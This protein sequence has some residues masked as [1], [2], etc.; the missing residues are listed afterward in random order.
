M[1]LRVV[2]PGPRTTVQDGGRFGFGHLGVPVAGAVDRLA[3]H[4]ANAA[5]GN[6]AD[7]AVLESV[8]GG[9]EFEVVASTT[10]AV[11]GA[12]AGVLVD[13]VDVEAAQA[14]SLTAGQRIR[15]GR[16]SGGVY[17]YVAIAGGVAVAPVLGSRSTDTLSRLGPPPLA[18]GDVV[19]AGAAGAGRRTAQVASHVDAD[20]AI[21]VFRGPHASDTDFA[22]LLAAAWTVT[23]QS[24]RVALRLSGPALRTAGRGIPSEG[25]VPGAIQLAPDGRPTV[26]LANHPVTGGYAVIGVVAWHAVPVIAQR[27]PGSSVRF[28]AA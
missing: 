16:A 8:L 4:A 5:V 28:V 6:E 1:T 21:A 20:S 24:D 9:D 12:T 27:R 7:A 18:A 17:V 19:A 22:E 10:I 26:F 2:R 11:S 14:I 3:V 13:G 25:L 15:I 23:P